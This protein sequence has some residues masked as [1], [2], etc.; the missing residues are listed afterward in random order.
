MNDYLGIA[1]AEQALRYCK[2]FLPSD[3][4]G[5]TERGCRNESQLAY[6]TCTARATLVVGSCRVAW[7]GPL[8]DQLR[9]H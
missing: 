9:M 7:L 5:I 8:R 4:A 3:F 6:H 2:D 1:E